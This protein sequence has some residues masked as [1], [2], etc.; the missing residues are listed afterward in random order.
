MTIATAPALASCHTAHTLPSSRTESR[1][2]L[3][4]ASVQWPLTTSGDRW[5]NHR[6]LQG[7]CSRGAHG[8]SHDTGTGTCARKRSRSPALLSRPAGNQVRDD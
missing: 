4:S 1:M 2:I 3:S 7:G 8:V 5:L 6:S